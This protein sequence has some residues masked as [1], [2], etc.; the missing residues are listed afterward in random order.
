M[1]EKIKSNTARCASTSDPLS[2][3]FKS[4][5]PCPRQLRHFIEANLT[6]TEIRSIW[7]QLKGACAFGHQVLWTG[8][9]REAA[10]K[11]ADSHD[12][13]TLTTAMGEYMDPKSERC[14][15]KKKTHATWIN[16][17]HGASALFALHISQ[18]EVVTVL[19]NPPPQRF[20]PEGN[21]S[22]QCIEGPI[23]TG[24]LGNRAVT[25]IEIV[26][27]KVSDFAYEVWPEDHVHTWLDR[28][29]ASPSEVHWRQVKQRTS[30]QLQQPV[31]LNETRFYDTLAPLHRPAQE[32]LESS[33][34]AE[35]Q[36]LL[37]GKLCERHVVENTR[38]QHKKEITAFEAALYKK[39]REFSSR[40]KSER[41]RL[42]EGHVSIM[43]GLQGKAAKKLAKQKHSQIWQKLIAMRRKQ[44][45]CMEQDERAGRRVLRERHKIEMGQ[46]RDQ[47]KH[48]QEHGI[49]EINAPAAE[50]QEI[51]PP[52]DILSR[53]SQFLRFLFR[54]A[55]QFW[56]AWTRAEGQQPR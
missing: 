45:T 26:H 25:R 40:R 33:K 35:R 47:Q 18:G 3:A 7:A 23:V 34:A 54:V 13:Q 17:I 14:P 53:F 49:Q 10:Q 19:S 12:M 2:V 42:H 44:M 50:A 28:Y 29:N 46:I 41:L 21:T 31:A 4:T 48:V 11:W 43:H 38:S 9:S 55:C 56:P 51:S 6:A 24:V 15:Q 36:P 5:Q 37:V 16:F 32:R 52:V 22:F 8:M 30:L 20:H 39:R 1:G 27:P